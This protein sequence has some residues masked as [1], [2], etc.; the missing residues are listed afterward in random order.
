M[1]LISILLAISM[2]ACEPISNNVNQISI[3]CGTDDATSL[4]SFRFAKLMNSLGFL[5][6]GEG[7]EV[8]T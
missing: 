6:T 2:L 3:E 8:R 4:G 5:E 1:R 7:I